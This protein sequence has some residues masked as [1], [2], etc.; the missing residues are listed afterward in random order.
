LSAAYDRLINDR[1]SGGVQAAW[2]KLSNAGPDP[3]S[4]LG[5]SVYLRYR[6]GDIR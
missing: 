6:L 3:R 2:R 1:I 5:G 4:D